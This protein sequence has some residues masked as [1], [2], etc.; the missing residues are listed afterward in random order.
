MGG[1][2]GWFVALEG[3]EGSGK[4]TQAA[5]LAERLRGAGRDVVE[6]REPGGTPL[7]EEARQMV[8]H[9]RDMP[10]AAELF[11]YLV[12][13]ADLVTHV[14]APALAAG[15]VVVADRFELSTRAYQ[16]AGRGLDAAQVQGAIALAVGGVMPDLYVVLDVSPETGRAR[17]EAQGKAPD[18]LERAAPGFHNRV[19]EAF[20]AARGPNVAHVAAGDDADT[21]HHAVWR[22]VQEQ[23]PR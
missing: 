11:L 9:G 8:L 7:A 12:A 10:A 22:I 20:R 4:T 17:Q 6:V 19:A 13:R 21:V 15:R 5:R 16:A 23:L 3:V 1:G 14:I 18:R 2:R